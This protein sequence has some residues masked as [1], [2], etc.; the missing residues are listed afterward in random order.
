METEAGDIFEDED[1]E[2]KEGE[3]DDARDRSKEP[4]CLVEG[5]TRF[6]SASSLVRTMTDVST[7]VVHSDVAAVCDCSCGC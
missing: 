5:D 7:D 3:G 1:E 6:S 2:D 4:D